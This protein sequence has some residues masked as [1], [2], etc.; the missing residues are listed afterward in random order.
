MRYA[1]QG[2]VDEMNEIARELGLPELSAEKI[3]E[4]I[5]YIGEHGYFILDMQDYTNGIVHVAIRKAGRGKW[6]N[7]FFRSFLRWAFTHTRVE[8]INAAIPIERT[9]VKMYAMHN[10]FI[11][12]Y[13]TEDFAY[14]Y[15][16]I[17]RWMMMDPECLTEGIDSR[18]SYK[19]ADHEMV[20]RVSGACAMM[21]DAGM[22]HKAWYV[23]ELYAKLFG[24]VA[25]G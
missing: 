25:E 3:M 22:E 24:Y 16:D 17:C 18:S 11:N 7:I 8:R 4:C 1:G 20:C 15:I 10:W 13:R 14:V 5:C 9:N 19:Y 12:A 21:H 6:A 23:Y 2:D